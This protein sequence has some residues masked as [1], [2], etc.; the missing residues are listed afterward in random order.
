[1]LNNVFQKEK[2]SPKNIKIAKNIAEIFFFV[3]KKQ[4]KSLHKGSFK[5]LEKPSDLKREHPALQKIKFID[6]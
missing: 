2:K 4:Q 5:L 3:I 6:C 1:V